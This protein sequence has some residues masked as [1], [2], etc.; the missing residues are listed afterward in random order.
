VRKPEEKSLPGKP[1]SRLEDNIKIDLKCN[2]RRGLDGSGSG[3][4]QVADTCEHSNEFP[5]CV[6]CGEFL[7]WLRNCELLI[8]ESALWS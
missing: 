4:G 2:W 8:K 3:F 7:D 1:R 6:K 5:G